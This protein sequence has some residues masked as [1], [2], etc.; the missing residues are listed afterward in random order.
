MISKWISQARVWKIVASSTYWPM[1][2][3]DVPAKSKL[4]KYW[5]PSSS[6]HLRSSQ[7]ASKLPRNLGMFFS[8]RAARKPISH[9]EVM[10]TSPS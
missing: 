8:M 4:S 1:S 6:S 7:M 10:G 2:A 3:R 9:G 5:S